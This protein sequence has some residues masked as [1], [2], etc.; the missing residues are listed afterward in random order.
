[1]ADK[2]ID[3][4]GQKCP[5]P[6][7]M[8]KRGLRDMAAGAVLELWATDPGSTRDFRS[9]ERLAGHRVESTTLPDGS[10]RHLITKAAS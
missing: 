6:L 8:A 5:M 9:L 4:R 7:L 10:F 3:A 1:M 2:Q